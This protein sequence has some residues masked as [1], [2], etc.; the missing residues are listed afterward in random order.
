MGKCGFAKGTEGEMVH[1]LTSLKIMK[2][3]RLREMLAHS[4]D[5]TSLLLLTMI[6]TSHPQ[7]D[8]PLH[9]LID[10]GALITGLSNQEVAS[11]LIDAGL[12]MDGVVFLGADDAKMIFEKKGR[13][14]IKLEDSLIP[15][16]RRFT[17]YDQ[18]H[19][20][21]TDIKHVPN[22]VACLTLGK[23]MNFRD[24]A[25]GAYR[26]RGI[27]LGQRINVFLVPEVEQLMRR[28]LGGL[29]EN[30]TLQAMPQEKRVLEDIACWLVINS[31]EAECKQFNFL[32]Q[33]VPCEG[34]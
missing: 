14:V 30:E 29:G 9:A 1:T 34:S 13:R 20:T 7:L 21:G 8:Q 12:P 31:L 19:T 4:K 26:M 10:T 16:E 6:A 23:D 18:T 2:P 11:H 24:Y 17:F 15:M 28:E 22:A 27:A 25:Q 32:M 33:Q 5:W 3:L